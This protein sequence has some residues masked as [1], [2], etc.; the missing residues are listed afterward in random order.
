MR[1]I[2]YLTL[3]F[4]TPPLLNAQET[5]PNIIIIYTDDQGYGDV[6]ALNPE[7][8]FKTPHLDSLINNGLA[9]TNAHSPDSIC[10]PSRYGL[11]TG[12]YSWRTHFKTGVFGAERKCLIGDDRLTIA[13]M[14]RTQGYATAMVGKWHLGMDFPGTDHSNRDWSKPILDMPLDKGFDYFY[15]IPASLNYGL[16]GWI[17][18]RHMAVPPTVFTNKKKNPRYLDYR[19]MPPYEETAKKSTDPTRTIKRNFEIAPDFIDNQCLTRF[20]DQAMKWLTTTTTANPEKPFFLYLPF[21]SPHYPVCPLP[22]FHGQGEAGPYGE[23]MI[24]TDHHIGRLMAHLKKHKLDQNTLILFSSDNGPE[25]SW[26]SRLKE[27]K[28]DSRGGFREGKRSVYEGGHRVPFIAHWPA[29]IIEPGR[30][31]SGLVGQVDIIAT[32]AQ[33]TGYQLPATAG[34]DSISFAPALKN[35]PLSSP[36]LPLINHGNPSAQ[37]AITEGSWKLIKGYKTKKKELKDQLYNLAED[38]SETTN[39]ATQ[40]PEKVKTLTTKL[41]TIITK[42]R[43]TPGPAQPNDTGHWKELRWLTPK[44]YQTLANQ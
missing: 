22:E 32:L 35:E 27:T 42:G 40:H 3:F 16:L 6:S 26:P 2:K 23:F 36:R 41:N 13:S 11:L 18:G 39:L 31:H 7:A 12:R 20:T 5:R 33:L 24:E 25:K 44:Q 14:L 17:E 38:P 43:T 29:G 28:H 9:F 34:E 21:T 30:K 1:I 4:L 19:I 10:T 15:G 37:Y 8:K